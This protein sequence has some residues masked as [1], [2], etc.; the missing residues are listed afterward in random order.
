MGVKRDNSCLPWPKVIGIHGSSFRDLIPS[1]RLCRRKR[2]REVTK[3][4]VAI[5]DKATL[6]C[7]PSDLPGHCDGGRP[8]DG[9]GGDDF[10]HVLRP[11]LLRP[12]D[13]PPPV[14]RDRHDGDCRDEDRG[15]LQQP[16][17]SAAEL[18]EQGRVILGGRAHG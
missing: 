4:C 13:Q 7:T 6:C 14:Q 17:H 1:L 11:L 2:V 5:G 3:F 12:H 8:D 9:Y 16:D 10:P 18:Q 15:R